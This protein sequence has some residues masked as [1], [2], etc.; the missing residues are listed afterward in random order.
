VLL[1]LKVVVVV[2]VLGWGPLHTHDWYHLVLRASFSHQWEWTITIDSFYSKIPIRTSKGLC[3]SESQEWLTLCTQLHEFGFRLKE[4]P[5]SLL[6]WKPEIFLVGIH[7]VLRYCGEMEPDSICDSR[8]FGCPSK[9]KMAH[10]PWKPAE[11]SGGPFLHST[12]GLLPKNK[13]PAKCKA[14][15]PICLLFFWQ[16]WGWTQCPCTC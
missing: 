4:S 11:L 9:A 1:C 2:A 15:C 6:L 14:F 10:W 7:A 3:N 16:Y 13:H 8:H 5:N 12:N